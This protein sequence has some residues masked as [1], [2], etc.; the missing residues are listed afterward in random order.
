MPPERPP[1]FPETAGVRLFMCAMDG[2]PLQV[3]EMGCNGFVGQKHELF[4]QLMCSV[5][6]DRLD[7]LDPSFSVEEEAC[8]P[9]GEFQRS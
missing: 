2:C 5:V 6:D 7:G 9:G 8:F 3:A 4:D 1:K